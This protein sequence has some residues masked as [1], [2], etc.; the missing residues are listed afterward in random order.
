MTKEPRSQAK[1]KS[2]GAVAIY[3]R[4]YASE[5][6]EEAAQTLFRLVQ[7][8]Q[9]T[10]PGAERLLFLD[11][12]GHRNEAGGFDS[13]MF[14]LQQRFVLGFLMQFLTQ[15]NMPLAPGARRKD[16]RPQSNNI[17]EALTIQHRDE[18]REE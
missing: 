14:E 17:P 3:H 12:D 10:S 7:Q 1:K 5:G 4:V 2:D 9:R 6:F 18:Q 8:A 16:D 15:V 13:D 11:I